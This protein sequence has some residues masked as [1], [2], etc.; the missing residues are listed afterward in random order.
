MRKDN[1]SLIASLQS[2]EN[3]LCKSIMDR[4]LVHSTLAQGC[5]TQADWV[6]LRKLKKIFEVLIF[7][8]KKLRNNSYGYKLKDYFKK[9][10]YS[11]LK[12]YYLILLS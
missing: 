9:F 2:L 6:N 7:H 10:F 11:T 12:I 8:M 4:V 5:Q 3:P 1:I